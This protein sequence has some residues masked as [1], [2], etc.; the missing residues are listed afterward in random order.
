MEKLESRTPHLDFLGFELDSQ[1]ME[2]RL[3]PTKLHE[4]QT[5]V[6]QWVGRKMCER[7]E[8]ESFVGKLA[9]TSNVVKLAKT[10]MRRMFELLGG[11]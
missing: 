5:L 1:A 2:V 8:L 11:A 10:F 3:C 9:H 7:R 4:L 6:H